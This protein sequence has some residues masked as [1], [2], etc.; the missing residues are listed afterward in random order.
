[1]SGEVKTKLLTRF[2][3][4]VPCAIKL[5]KERLRVV[6]IRPVAQANSGGS[7][8][9]AAPVRG[10]VYPTSLVATSPQLAAAVA[11]DCVF[12]CWCLNSFK[13]EVF[14]VV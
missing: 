10:V 5:K 6:G 9:E 12:E 13:A 14:V 2:L 1:V 8:F 11:V 7:K 3:Q 4:L